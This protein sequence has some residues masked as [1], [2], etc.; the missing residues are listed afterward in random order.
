MLP[1]LAFCILHFAF[2]IL[3][4][5]LAHAQNGNEEPPVAG[6]P[7]DFSGLAGAFR[8]SASA[9]PTEVNVEDP[10]TLVVRITGEPDRSFRSN[11]PGQARLRVF[12]K[13]MNDD[14]FIEA[15]PE[16]D[17]YLENEKTWEFVYRLRPKRE[18]VK[19]IPGLKLVYYFPPRRKYQTSYADE[20]D[21]VVKP[22][23][24][25]AP[26]AETVEASRLPAAFYELASGADV[27]R[28]PAQ[29]PWLGPVLGLFLILPPVVCVLWY[30]RWR[31]LHPETLARERRSQAAHRALRALH[32]HPQP[33]GEET[34]ALVTSYLRQRLDLP[35]AEPTPREVAQHLNRLSVSKQLRTR[36]ADFFRACDAARFAGT[37][38]NGLAEEAG[39]IIHALEKVASWGRVPKHCLNARQP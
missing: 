17:R 18:T 2:C 27:L 33:G 39:Q 37:A 19:V 12:P 35:C 7:E 24:K 25:A 31:R 22:R 32:H 9:T 36:V 10:I 13:Q 30:R 38:S 29:W 11:Q 8:I 20:I 6:R 21:L 34:F 1:Y 26:T 14:F 4:C 28:R 5:S 16:K 15:V 3:H 23:P